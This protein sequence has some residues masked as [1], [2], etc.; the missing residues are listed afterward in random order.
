MDVSNAGY[1]EDS[2][3]LEDVDLYSALSILPKNIDVEHNAMD[4]NLKL[5]ES[6]RSQ[7][8]GKELGR[9]KSKKAATSLEAKR[10]VIDAT[11]LPDDGSESKKKKGGLD[12]VS[13]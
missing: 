3:P 12:A 2:E 11:L 6:A 1:S 9:L 7:L 5:L 4:D 8:S 13:V 10:K